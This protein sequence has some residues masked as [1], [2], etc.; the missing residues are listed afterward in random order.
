MPRTLAEID[1]DIERLRSER[2]NVIQ[3]RDLKEMIKRRLDGYNMAGDINTVSYGSDDCIVFTFDNGKENM[4][5]LGDMSTFTNWLWSETGYG[6]HALWVNGS[7]KLTMYLRHYAIV[8]V[9][10][11]PL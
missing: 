8:P 1:A 10:E 11:R 3:G 7:D 9:I 2:V 6:I 4:R 5:R